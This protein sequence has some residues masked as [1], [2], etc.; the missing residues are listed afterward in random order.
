MRTLQNSAQTALLY[1]SGGD[2]ELLHRPDRD[3]GVHLGQ[4]QPPRPTLT[5]PEGKR[6]DFDYNNNDKR[7]KT[8]YPGGTTQTVTI[9]E[10]RPPGEDQDH[11]RHA[12]LRRPDL[13]LHQRGQGLYH[14]DPHPHRQPHQVQDHLH[15]RLPGGSPLLRAGGG[16]SRGAKGV[17]AVPA[18]T[19]PATSPAETAA[20][21]TL[22]PGGTTSPTTTPPELTGRMDPPP[23]GLTSKLGNETGAADSTPARARS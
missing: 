10:Q 12:D 8:V 14:Q 23:A 1:T 7:T 13:Q 21:R 18:G 6:T 17:V 20:A 11:L 2:V 16:L 15:L 19:R 4:G 22:Y 9:D 3:D 5:A